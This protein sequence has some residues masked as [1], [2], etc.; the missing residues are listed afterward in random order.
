MG[1]GPWHTVAVFQVRGYAGRGSH[2]RASPAPL[3]PESSA[4]AAPT[5]ECLEI[6][7]IE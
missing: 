1:K 5:D 6:I 4:A 3:R 2:G 7:T